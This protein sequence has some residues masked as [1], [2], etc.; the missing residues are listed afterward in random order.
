M[1]PRTIVDRAQPLGPWLV[2]P[3]RAKRLTASTI[4]TTDAT[5]DHEMSRMTRLTPTAALPALGLA[6]AALLVP[7]AGASADD[8]VATLPRDTPIAAYGGTVAWSDF[9]ATTSQ[10]RLVIRRGDVDQQAPIAG[11]PR[12][13]DVS[14]GPDVHGRVVALYTRCREPETA[15]RRETGCDV[16][17]YD[18]ASGREHELASVSSP[19][20]DEAWPSQWRDR[21]AFVRRAK[22][23]VSNGY[24]HSPDPRGK[25]GQRV[26][27]D[28]DIPYVKTLSSRRAS[29]RLDRGQCGVTTGASLRGTHIVLVS[30]E[31]QGGAGSEGQVR[32][33]RTSGGAARILARDGGGEDG[34]APYAS[35]SQS[36]TAAF[37]TRTGDR[38]AK[39]FVRLGLR[40]RS[41]AEV[42]PQLPLAGRVVRDDHGVFWYVQAPEAAYDDFGNSPPPFCTRPFPTR[43]SPLLQPCRLVRASADPFSSALRTLPPRLTRDNAGDDQIRGS[44]TDAITISGGLSRSVVRAGGPAGGRIVGSQPLAGVTLDLLRNRAITG[45]GAWDTTAT[46]TTTDAAGHWSFTLTRPASQA[47]F[48]VVAPALGLASSQVGVLASAKLT[49]TAAGTSLS[50]TLTPAQ[51]G[52]SVDIQRLEADGVGKL[53]NGIPRC[54]GPA[55]GGQLNCVEQAWITVASP[56]PTAGGTAFAAAV[57]GPGIYRASLALP[58]GPDGWPTNPDL[59]GGVS[60]QV[61][62]GM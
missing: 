38:Q 44:Y 48:V 57:T 56:A 10:Y 59:Y 50:G 34:Y 6:L 62:I 33:L 27:M 1:N 11:A 37:V 31:D 61:R 8:V 54:M 14:L 43:S 16:Y 46:T 41:I 45:N 20:M 47:Y 58:L 53:P 17:R 3:V 51:P 13:F 55:V 24:D 52:R 39:D 32:F 5:K 60:P 7:A 4:T 42:D 28:C 18:V 19:T 49:L 15:T 30:D 23:Y 22:T 25:G 40:S 36:A 35:P 29:R 12:P 9:D 2:Y 21:I 26:L